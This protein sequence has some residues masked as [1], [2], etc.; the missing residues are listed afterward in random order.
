MRLQSSAPGSC[1]I[2]LPA[3]ARRLGLSER[4]L[5]RRLVERGLLWKDLVGR[6]REGK[7]ASA[8]YPRQARRAV[9][10]ACNPAGEKREHRSH[11]RLVVLRSERLEQSGTHRVGRYAQRCRVI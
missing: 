6:S 8:L 1:P 5:Q 9:T 7:T 4:M 3:A 11:R 10:S 2:A